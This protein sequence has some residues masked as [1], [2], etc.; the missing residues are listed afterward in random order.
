MKARFKRRMG[1]GE[2]R[3]RPL[4][5]ALGAFALYQIAAIALFGRALLANFSRLHAGGGPDPQFYIWSLLW[6]PYALA[7]RLNP[8]I[9][10]I[11]WRPDGFNLAWATSLPLQSLVA[12]P[13]T[14]ALWTRG[15]L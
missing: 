5:Q 6:W 9:T 3:T 4:A 2:S 11:I 10:Q 15:R 1:N 7:H 14:A 12:A 13:I 8:F